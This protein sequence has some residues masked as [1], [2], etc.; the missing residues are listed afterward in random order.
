[1]QIHNEH[2]RNFQTYKYVYPVVSRRSKGLSL[3]INLNPDGKCTYN[4]L[5]CQVPEHEKAATD[6][7]DLSILKTE[8][9]S[10]V[11]QIISGEI[12]TF[13]PFCHIQDVE[14]KVFR[15]IAIA[16][17]G[18]PTIVPCLPEVM[19]IIA[20][21]SSEYKLPHTVLITNAS[22]LHTQS[23]KKAMK[24]LAEIKGCV[25]AKL[26]AGS[27]EFHKMV[28]RSNVSL[29]KITENIAALPT[30]IS[31]FIQTCWFAWNNQLPTATEILLYREKLIQ[32]M[33][34]R[35]ITG[36]QIYTVARQPR[37]SQVSPI[38]INKLQELA[39]PLK[40]LPLNIEF[41]E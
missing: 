3:G 20:E 35:P 38:A 7:V 25:W 36:I 13:E 34:K 22:G 2:P 17:N 31:L 24:V 23:S 41:Y 14:K 9:K 40:D 37:E 28:N 8:L 19:E 15:D 30:E 32:I 5:Y 6:Q 33:N 10:V 12:F 4:C 16:G 29:E 26:D 11:A 21:L 39:Q 18:E 27:H 1:M